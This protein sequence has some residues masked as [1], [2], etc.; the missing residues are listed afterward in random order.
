MT[1]IIVEQYGGCTSLFEFP[2]ALR[3]D[4]ENT[5]VK[6]VL[7]SCQ[8]PTLGMSVNGDPTGRYAKMEFKWKND[9]KTNPWVKDVPIRMK[10]CL[11]DNP[12]IA[13]VGCI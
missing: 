4:E 10:T 6:C 13:E 8:L 5:A 1:L 11:R 2:K 7:W 12:C 3:I 9:V